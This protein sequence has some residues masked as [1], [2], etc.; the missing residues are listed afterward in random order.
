MCMFYVV[1][2][3]S[4]FDSAL[5]LDTK[6]FSKYLGVGMLKRMRASSKCICLS[7]QPSV[8][9]EIAHYV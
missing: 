5:F 9:C 6:Y 2:Y 1:A 4:V 7:V 8:G 3:V